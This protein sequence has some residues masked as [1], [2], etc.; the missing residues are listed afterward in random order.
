M[1]SILQRIK[2]ACEYFVLRRPRSPKP[3]KL[4]VHSSSLVGSYVRTPNDTWWA[5]TSLPSL[6]YAVRLIAPGSEPTQ[7]QLTSF[8]KL[9]QRL[10]ALIEQSRLEPPPADDGWG[11]KPPKFDIHL[12]R[13]SS[14]WIRADGS[15]FLT[16]EV[17]TTKVY[18]L[19]PSF[20]VSPSIELIS[21]EWCV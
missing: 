6:G 12:A 15:F 4:D 8:D 17:D 10:P 9:V 13:I 21:A 11:N 18:M 19:A 20:E 16:F 5:D 3:R 14:M 1:R 7:A 2:F